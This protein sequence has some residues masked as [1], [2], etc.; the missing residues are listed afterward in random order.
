M[1]VGGG[2]GAAAEDEAE[3][4]PAETTRTHGQN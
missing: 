2:R 4:G 3:L 1:E